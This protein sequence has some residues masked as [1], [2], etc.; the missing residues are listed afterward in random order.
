M[1]SYP[2]YINH[3]SSC[4]AS[5]RGTTYGAQIVL[6]LEASLTATAPM[7][8]PVVV[9][10]HMLSS[11]LWAAVGT[12]ASLTLK[13]WTSMAIDIHMVLS[14][15]FC[16][17]F[18]SARLAGPVADGVHVLAGGMVVYKGARAYIAFRHCDVGWN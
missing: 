10:I 7:S 4:K 13:T 2:L 6:I 11:F 14:S 9:L 3:T 18:I 1:L 15:L 8:S 5:I 16:P 12:V 17:K